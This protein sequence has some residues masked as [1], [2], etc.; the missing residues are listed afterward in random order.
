MYCVWMELFDECNIK[1]GTM[2]KE[3]AR[4]I[5]C[6]FVSCDH[7]D[8]IV[9]YTREPM[10]N[11]QSIYSEYSRWQQDEFIGECKCASGGI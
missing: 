10:N 11:E 7:V 5:K 2:L 3:L 1:W 8:T 6:S 9:L 4:D